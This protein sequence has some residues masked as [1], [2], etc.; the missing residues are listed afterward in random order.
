MSK[1]EF[2]P[3][4]PPIV[5]ILVPLQEPKPPT[6]SLDIEDVMKL[7][8]EREELEKKNNSTIK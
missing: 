8:K 1:N 5:P 6:T 7:L 3:N 4:R 2:N